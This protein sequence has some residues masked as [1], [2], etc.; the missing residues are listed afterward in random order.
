MDPISK[1]QADSMLINGKAIM[2]AH[3]EAFGA[4]PYPE[5]D[6]VV[7]NF[8]RFGGMEYP[9]L[10]MQDPS[11]GVLVHELAHQWWF[12]IVGD[13]EY[14]E[15]WLDEAFASYATD[16]YFGSDG[17]G[18]QL[19]WPSETARVTNS[20][21]YWDLHTTEYFATV[22]GIGACSLHDLGRV[23]GAKRMAKFIRSYA[24]DHALAWS[25]TNAFKRAAQAVADTLPD[26]VHLR[27]FWR[28]HR[29]DDVP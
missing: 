16:R 20:M 9:T 4:F 1:A 28:Q 24:I 26:P 11:V 18:C 6:V 13:D 15:P 12:G 29:I 7:G 21:E 25:T 2:A 23:L 10:V 27:P 22:Y 19:N 14:T 5:V 8:T 3:A 17:E